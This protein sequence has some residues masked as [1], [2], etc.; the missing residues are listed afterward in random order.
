MSG[1]MTRKVLGLVRV[2]GDEQDLDRQMTD[3]ERV[4]NTHGLIIERTLPLEDVSGRTVLKNA[5]VLRLL[6]E[7]KRPDICGVAVAALDRLFGPTVMKTSPSWITSETA[8]S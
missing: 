4:R 3:L 8:A 5:E 7:L 1:K 2:S 6:D